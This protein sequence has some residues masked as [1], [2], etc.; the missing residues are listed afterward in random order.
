MHSLATAFRSDEPGLCTCLT[1]FTRAG[2]SSLQ[3]LPA[4]L[5]ARIWS[6]FKP[7]KR[8]YTTDDLLKDLR[9]LAST[10]RAF[11][12]LWLTFPSSLQW[13]P[14][15]TDSTLALWRQHA[16]STAARSLMSC[17]S[18][19]WLLKTLG[20]EELAH[21]L[22]E[23]HFWHLEIL[24]HLDQQ[25]LQYLTRQQPG[26]LQEQLGPAFACCCADQYCSAPEGDDDHG[27]IGAPTVFSL[28]L[29]HHHAVL[30]PDEI[31]MLTAFVRHMPKTVLEAADDWAMKSRVASC[32]YLRGQT[33]QLPLLWQADSNITY[34]RE[35][36]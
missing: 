28:T 9:A 24:L 30:P 17:V 32:C 3:A 14:R 11:R 7:L 2:A 27:V 10:C 12:T 21:P 15:E 29:V 33:G 20:D 16:S 4:H 22:L 19:R 13:R 31:A 18:Q 25:T 8:A 36:G 5:Q 23:D 6:S 35:L 1:S 26:F 34:H